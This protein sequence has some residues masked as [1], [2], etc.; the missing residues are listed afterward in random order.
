MANGHLPA[1]LYPYQRRL[2]S[3][4]IFH[5]RLPVFFA[6][7]TKPA[8]PVSGLPYPVQHR[9][10][11]CAFPAF[12]GECRKSVFPGRPRMGILMVYQR[13]LFYLSLLIK[14]SFH[15]FP[16]HHFLP[17]F[18]LR[19]PR[20][21]FPILFKRYAAHT[22]LEEAGVPPLLEAPFSPVTPNDHTANGTIVQAFLPDRFVPV[23]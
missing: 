7:S 2:L 14:R 3:G 9:Y 22:L 8:L 5:A 15:L 1:A 13:K 17:A 11:C 18:P 10:R 21:H 16:R 23:L 20:F 19:I 12:Q 4:A 6:D